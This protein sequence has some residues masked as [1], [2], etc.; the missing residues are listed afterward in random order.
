MVCIGVAVD[1]QGHLA[2]RHQMPLWVWMLWRKGFLLAWMVRLV[3]GLRA[4]LQPS[5]VMAPLPPGSYGCQLYV[6][7]P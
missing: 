2:M 4:S 1:A 6:V 5:L 7:P 3:L